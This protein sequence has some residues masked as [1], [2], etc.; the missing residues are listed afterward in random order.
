MAT[1]NTKYPKQNEGSAAESKGEEEPP[2]QG[3]RSPQEGEEEEEDVDDAEYRAKAEE[4]GAQDGILRL[5]GEI[6]ECAAS[7]RQGGGED[8]GE[9]E[10]S[11]CAR[12]GEEIHLRSGC[13]D[14]A[15]PRESP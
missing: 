6:P 9:A 8:E 2:R 1:G 11:R 10:G 3:Q 14:S 7:G 12:S 5:T 15:F 13:H 4:K